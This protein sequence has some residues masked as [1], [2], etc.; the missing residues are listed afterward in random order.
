MFLAPD[1]TAQGQADYIVNTTRRCWQQKKKN[2]RRSIRDRVGQ[3]NGYTVITEET[4]VS[5]LGKIPSLCNVMKVD[6]INL[7]AAYGCGILCARITG[8][9]LRRA[10][11]QHICPIPEPYMS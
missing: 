7:T 5:R 6:C 10:I 11:G 4:D 3:V 2:S 9:T 1:E 8:K